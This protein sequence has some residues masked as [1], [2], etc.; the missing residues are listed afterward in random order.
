M[1][2]ENL[3][4]V[5][6]LVVQGTGE[7]S[8]ALSGTSA[9]FSSS[10]TANTL[11]VGASATQNGRATIAT[12]ADQYLDIVNTVETSGKATGIRFGNYSDTDGFKKGGIFYK[13]SGDGY[14]RGD[15]IIALN[16]ALNSNN[17]TPSNA[18]L[19]FTGTTGAATFSGLTLTLNNTGATGSD[20]ILNIQSL[21]GGN[22]RLK[23]VGTSGIINRGSTGDHMYFGETSDTGNYYIRG[24][25][26][27]DINGPGGGSGSVS[28]LLIRN[29]NTSDYFGNNQIVLSY[30]SSLNYAHAIKSRHNSAGDGSGKCN[31]FLY[32]ES[33]RFNFYNWW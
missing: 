8:G 23:F 24:T 33:W 32:M 11:L 1:I 20:P 17:A 6:S 27:F 22:P 16:T 2:S 14:S 25:G 30:S 9:T 12:S 3:Y 31:R 7:F 29:G 13:S 15:L 26:S 21:G 28:S 18:V 5:A 19:T 4:Q 10:V